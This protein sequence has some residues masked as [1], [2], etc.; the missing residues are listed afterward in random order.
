[1]NVR[2]PDPTTTVALPVDDHTSETSGIEES[3]IHSTPEGV[4]CMD[5]RR[6]M[7]WCSSSDI[8]ESSRSGSSLTWPPMA[9]HKDLDVG[10]CDLAS[11]MRRGS[12]EACVG[13]SSRIP[14]GT[15]KT[16]S[17]DNIRY[18]PTHSPLTYM[19]RE[20][21]THTHTQLHTHTHTRQL[22][23]LTHQCR[24]VFTRSAFRSRFPRELSQ[25]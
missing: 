7:G 1:M 20:G 5:R 21:P 9:L 23:T 8:V 18:L 12:A 4:S 24:D 17:I 3:D 13:T 6:S 10:D 11:E 22:H 2:V 16:R 19:Y 14:P 15:R 25:S